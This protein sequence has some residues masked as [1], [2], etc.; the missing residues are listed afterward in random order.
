MRVSKWLSASKNCFKYEFYLIFYSF[1]CFLRKRMKDNIK[2]CRH[3]R[4]TVKSDVFFCLFQF[5]PQC[6]F[7]RKCQAKFS[8]SRSQSRFLY[9][10]DLI[11]NYIYLFQSIN[12]SID[13]CTEESTLLQIY[14]FNL[15]SIWSFKRA[16][17]SFEFNQ[18]VVGLLLELVVMTLLEFFQLSIKVVR[19]SRLKGIF[20]LLVNLKVIDQRSRRHLFLNLL[21]ALFF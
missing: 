8:W 5:K 10:I 14:F 3:R 13:P 19:T 17:L 6:S 2:F 15:N 18:D 1:E 20:L 21:F 16:I 7:V 4:R 9:N 12:R 11:I